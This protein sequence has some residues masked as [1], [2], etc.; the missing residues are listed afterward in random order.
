MIQ[1]LLLSGIGPRPYLSSWGI[2]VAH[3]LRYVGHFL[4]DNPRNGITFLPSVP[5]EHTLI[6]VVGITD[7]GAYIEAASNVVPFS[8]LQQMV[9]IRP[10]TSPLH[11]TIATLILKISG[12]DSA[13]FLRLAESDNK[14][15][16]EPSYTADVPNDAGEKPSR[17]PDILITAGAESGTR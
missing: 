11:L 9:F 4:Y 8:T 14:P 1:L 2:P 12:P 17:T 7:S 15:W 3:H 10:A 13:G 5:L 6:E 16:T